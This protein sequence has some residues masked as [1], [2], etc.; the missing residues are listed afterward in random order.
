MVCCVLCGVPFTRRHHVGWLA[1]F[2][3]VWV[4]GYDFETVR[5]SGIGRW[6]YDPTEDED[7]DDDE[8]DEDEEEEEEEE[9]DDE[10][11]QVGDG[12]LVPIHF[13]NRWNGLSGPGPRIRVQLD[14]STPQCYRDGYQGWRGTFDRIPIPWG[15]VFHA[16]CWAVLD[17]L[18]TPDLRH[19]FTACLST[20]SY[21]VLQWGH[22]YQRLVPTVRRL[23][24]DPSFEGSLSIRDVL[25][26][27]LRSDPYYIQ[28]VEVAIA[29]AACLQNAVLSSRLDLDQESLSKD[30]FCHLPTDIL[31]MIAILLPTSDIRSLRLASPVFAT[32]DLSETFWVSRVKTGHG[33]DYLF[34]A[35]DLPPKSCR[36][37]YLSLTAWAPMIPGISNR[38]RV[39]KLAKDLQATLSQMTD[40]P[41]RGR[42][43]GIW[44]EGKGIREREISW[45]TAER[46]IAQEN[47]CFHEGCRPLRAR[48]L[49]FP[50]P[51]KV[52]RMSVSFVTV[53]AGKFISG[54]HFV[55]Q[56][57]LSHAIGYQHENA[58]I[59]IQP[60]TTQ[61]IQGWELAL[62]I[63]GIKAISIIYEDGTSS[64]WAGDPSNIPRW[65]LIGDQCVSSIKAEFDVRISSPSFCGSV[66]NTL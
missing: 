11:V 6:D 50:Q 63:S 1:E 30:K 15:F 59:H 18:F 16:S 27:E 42:P 4:R 32:T 9:I 38:K 20:P 12:Q 57:D 65:R 24:F 19:L 31:E 46:G 10:S 22:N 28:G 29:R 49:Y 54:L 5:L 56:D 23:S 58:M 35:R 60:P 14:H 51:L 41:C 48:A 45:H 13:T 40:V 2:R 39:W 61:C 34:E 64:A 33:L 3:A 25:Y 21:G 37:L 66:S 43:L 52:Q 47:D 8:D 44:F 53:S 17:K 62:D 7:E 26:E 36:T 55:N